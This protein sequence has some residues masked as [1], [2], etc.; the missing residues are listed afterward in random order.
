[1]DPANCEAEGMTD[2]A[3]KLLEDF[4]LLSDRERCQVVA[5]LVRR[6]A[7]S[8]HDLPDDQ[9][10]TAAADQVFLVLDRHEPALEAPHD[11]MGEIP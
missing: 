8:S 11:R 2:M 3:R 10:L 6:V 7:I 5:E 4:E 9:D 1:M